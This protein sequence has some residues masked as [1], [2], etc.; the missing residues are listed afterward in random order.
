M[1][2]DADALRAEMT[3]AAAKLA[4]P[5][6]PRLRQERAGFR[7]AALPAGLPVCQQIAEGGAQLIQSRR[8]D[9]FRPFGLDCGRHCL[10]AFIQPPAA[11]GKPDPPRVPVRGVGV[12]RSRGAVLLEATGAFVVALAARRSWFCHPQLFAVLR[13]FGRR[14][15][16]RADLAALPRWAGGFLG[17]AVAGPGARGQSASCWPPAGPGRVGRW[18]GRVGLAA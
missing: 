8:P 7:A 5:V 17:H 15:T 6:E 18:G 16:G 10:D 1:R 2:A 9:L 11:A 14:R 3:G 13:L 12:A 4:R